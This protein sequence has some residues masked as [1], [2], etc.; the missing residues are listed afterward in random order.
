MNKQERNW[1]RLA[2]LADVA[3]E[4]VVA[5]IRS[6]LVGHKSVE[7][8]FTIMQPPMQYFDRIPTGSSAARYSQSM[9]TYWGSRSGSRTY[10]PYL[11]NHFHFVK[12]FEP[13]RT[14]V[15]LVQVV[16]FEEMHGTRD[17]IEFTIL[18]ALM[19]N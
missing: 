4:H 11:L 17:R 18:I 13:N 9:A 1:K 2:G 8:H 16:H 10:S 14:V 19:Y 3:F 5:V 6:N 7:Q 12:S 15:V